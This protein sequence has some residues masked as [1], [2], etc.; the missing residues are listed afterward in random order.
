MPH[1]RGWNAM[2]THNHG[3]MVTLYVGIVQLLR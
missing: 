2:I 1:H 3:I